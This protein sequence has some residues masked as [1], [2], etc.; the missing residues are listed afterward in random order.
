MGTAESR[1]AAV[2]EYEQLKDAIEK[3]LGAEL[4]RDGIEPT[5]FDLPIAKAMLSSGQAVLLQACILLY[6]QSG[7]LDDFILLMD[8]PENHLHPSACIDL[9]E[10]VRKAAPNCQIWIATHSVAVLSY[11]QDATLVFAHEGNLSK[12]GRTPE[13]VLSTLVGNEER[14]GRLRS[15]LSLPQEFALQKYAAECLLP[16]K[17]IGASAG[18]PQTEQIRTAL[19]EL[20][21]RS[22]SGKLR[23][24][25]FGAGKGRLLENLAADFPDALAFL[26]YVAFDPSPSDATACRVAIEQAYGSHKKRHFQT[27]TELRGTFDPA[28]FDIVVMCNLLHEIRPT[29]WI[30][31]FEEG[32]TV[33][34]LLREGGAFFIVEDFAIPTGEMPHE[35]GFIVL[36]T[37]ELKRLF[38]IPENE[39]LEVSTALGGRL[40]T[41]LIRREQAVRINPASRI[42]AL[43]ESKQR[44]FEEVRALRA[45]GMGSY[46]DGLRHAF[47][48]A[49]YANASIALAE[50]DT[51]K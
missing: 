31:I 42:G 6:A 26:D 49:Q 25:D 29:S 35:G 14:V 11:Y 21:Q 30:E 46:R 4:S 17:T 18:D 12:A 9:I 45:N 37:T 15:F 3:L 2:L 34:S 48:L 27:L 40:K 51:S 7:K 33:C 23:L 5:L 24:L 32:G 38:E 8:E 36:D 50:L 22:P 20:R 13:L 43:R 47:W 10:G 28:S 1:A 16:P 39:Q 44:A 41:H 19:D